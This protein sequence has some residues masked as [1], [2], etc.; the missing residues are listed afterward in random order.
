MCITAGLTVSLAYFSPIDHENR[1]LTRNAD[2][3]KSGTN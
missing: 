1:V 2:I 3:V